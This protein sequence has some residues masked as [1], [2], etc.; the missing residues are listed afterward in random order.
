M[1][2]LPRANPEPVARAD[3]EP[4][5]EQPERSS[6]ITNR[7]DG[8]TPRP[9]ETPADPTPAEP[10]AAVDAAPDTAEPAGGSYAGHD[11]TDADLPVGADSAA[12]PFLEPSEHDW[13]PLAWATNPPGE[14]AIHADSAN[15]NQERKYLAERHPELARVNERYYH[16]AAHSDGYQTNCTRAV[17][18]LEQ[19][20]LGVD[21]HAEPL[22]PHE[23]EAKGTLD[24]VKDRLGGRWQRYSDYESVIRHMNA[25]PDGARAV[26]GVKYLSNADEV[27][28][29][30]TV[31][32]TPEGVAFVDPQSG[33][34]M[35]LTHPPVHIELLS[36][37]PSTGDAPLTAAVA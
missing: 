28:H 10:D 31:I 5:P 35:R 7:L 25:Q 27:G 20:L 6:P 32:K 13:R 2:E 36:Y 17:V 11:G 23:L 24:Y 37:H 4:A 26:I 12:R 34:L 3:P 15:W 19:R 21:A 18:A 8:I 29:V 14:P 16:P 30:A 9:I 33:T 1:P 22:S